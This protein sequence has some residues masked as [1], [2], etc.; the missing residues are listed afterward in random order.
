[1]WVLVQSCWVPKQTRND[2]ESFSRGR[3]TVLTVFKYECLKTGETGN[4]SFSPCPLHKKYLKSCQGLDSPFHL[5]A[6][7]VSPHLK[8]SLVNDCVVMEQS[9]S[10]IIYTIAL[11]MSTSQH[12]CLRYAVQN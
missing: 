2:E 6:L 1:M 7:G 4:L 8:I 3:E 12:L 11:K 10:L 5:F 9:L